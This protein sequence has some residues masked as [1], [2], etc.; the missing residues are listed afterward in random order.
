M[1]DGKTLLLKRNK[2]Q[3]EKKVKFNLKTLINQRIRHFFF[4]SLQ[5]VG[6]N[7][8]DCYTVVNK[9]KFQLCYGIHFRT[10]TLDKHMNPLIAQAMA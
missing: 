4:G 2:K 8:L 10:N 5:G 9:C 7:I 1:Y 6:T 3:N